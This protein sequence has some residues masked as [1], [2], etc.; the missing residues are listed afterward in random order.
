MKGATNLGRTG[1]IVSIL[2]LAALGGLAG[3]HGTRASPGSPQA[4]I[5]A[6]KDRESSPNDPKVIQSPA[7]V[8]A[9]SHGGRIG[10]NWGINGERGRKD[11]SQNP[12]PTPEDSAP[13]GN[14]KV[15]YS[16]GLGALPS[17]T[18]AREENPSVQIGHARAYIEPKILQ[19]Q[20]I[21]INL[22]DQVL[23]IFK[24]GKLLDSYPVSTGKSGMDTPT[25]THAIASK[26][27]RAWSQKYGLFM[28]YWMAITP[29]GVFGIHELPES[30]DGYTD[31]ADDLGMP[32]SHG[33]VR[34]GIGP[35]ERVYNWAKIGTPVLVY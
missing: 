33:C 23:S 28:P 31:G 15:V 24:D 32:V 19:G 14:C 2:A 7:P 21:D 20:Y 4:E 8:V 35:A 25:G 1:W 5:P 34:L 22:A 13:E 16:P 29:D 11:A 18:Q 12:G 27:P 26:C 3:V 17:G 30:P 9:G 10:A 6:G